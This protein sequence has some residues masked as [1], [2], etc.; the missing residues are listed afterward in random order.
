MQ[1]RET[2]KFGSV[3]IILE[4]EHITLYNSLCRYALEFISMSWL[5]YSKI[6]KIVFEI[7]VNDLLFLVLDK[8]CLIKCNLTI[9]FKV[10]CQR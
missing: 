2:G 5:H 7:F 6:I 9:I 1:S 10:I 4:W 3:F 8:N